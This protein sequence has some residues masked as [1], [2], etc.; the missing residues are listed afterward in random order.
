MKSFFNFCV[1]KYEE[2]DYFFASFINTAVRL[3]FC[4]A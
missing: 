3:G 2:Q 1:F 4:R